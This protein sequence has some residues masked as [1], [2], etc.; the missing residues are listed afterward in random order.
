MNHNFE[1]Y[2]FTTLFLLNIQYKIVDFLK[3][4]MILHLFI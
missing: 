3:T 2:D 1:K 4:I